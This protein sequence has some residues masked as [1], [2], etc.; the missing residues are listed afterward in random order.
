MELKFAPLVYAPLE[1]RWYPFWLESNFY[2]STQ[3]AWTIVDGFDQISFH[4]HNY[5]SMKGTVELKFT[6]FCSS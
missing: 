4:I 2:D 5:S 3:N 1:V 6:S